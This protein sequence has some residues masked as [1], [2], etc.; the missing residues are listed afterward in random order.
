VTVTIPASGKALVIL[1][2]Q[3]FGST[4]NSA[5]F[6]SV[7][8]SGATTVAASDANSLRVAGNDA[9]RASATAL[10]TGL[11][12]GSNTFTAKYKQVG[13]GTATFSDRNIVVIPLS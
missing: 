4:G 12:P 1:T 2:G 7:A 11:T 13:S 5:A 8:V 3:L 9:V 10:I 6:M